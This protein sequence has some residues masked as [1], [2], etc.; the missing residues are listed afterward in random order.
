MHVV[1]P[2]LEQARERFLCVRIVLDDEHAPRARRRLCFRRPGR[3]R[4][5]RFFG[6]QWQHDLELAALA[7][8]FAARAHC[9]TVQLDERTR[10]HWT[11]QGLR[12]RIA[13]RRGV[14][15]DR[16]EHVLAGECLPP[17]DDMG[18]P[19]AGREGAVAHG[20]ELTALSEVHRYSDDLGSVVL[21]Q[22]GDT[23]R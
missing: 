12:H 8:A 6:Q 17:V 7:D 10:Q 2:Q 11:S 9:A 21:L 15:P 18:A 14:C 20:F 4:D 5:A 1:P 22:P 13:V 16:T 23:E 3:R 19:R